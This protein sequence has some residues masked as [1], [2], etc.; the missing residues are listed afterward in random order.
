MGNSRPVVVKHMPE[1]INS[2]TARLFLR[3]VEPFF[4]ADRPQVV[5]DCSRVKQMDVS[6]V[7]LLVRCMSRAMKQDGDLK[8]ASLSAAV[9]VVLEMTRSD[10]LFEI[11]KTASDAVRSFSGFLPNAM[12]DYPDWSRTEPLND[13]RR[14]DFDLAA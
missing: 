11:Y 12:R 3:E 10:R 9:A 2:E 5:F 14:N 1:R 7:D 8:L 13:A 4:K 6:G